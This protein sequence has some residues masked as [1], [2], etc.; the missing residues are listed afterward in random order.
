MTSYGD[1]AKICSAPTNDS[2]DFSV[3]NVRIYVL[4]DYDLLLYL[5]SFS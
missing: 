5:F 1:S 3:S 2:T 4:Y